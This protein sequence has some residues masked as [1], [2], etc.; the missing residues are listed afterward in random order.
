MAPHDK[1]LCQDVLKSRQSVPSEVAKVAL[2]VL[3]T[4]ERKHFEEQNSAVIFM[5][6]S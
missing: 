2:I 6:L 5:T 4:L 1:G 3:N